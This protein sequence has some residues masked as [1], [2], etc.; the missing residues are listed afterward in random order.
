MK[1][2]WA[3]ASSFIFLMFTAVALAAPVPD[4]GQAK[5]YDVAG[6]VITCPSP[7]QALY[8]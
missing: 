5:C 7:G 1:K 8:G 4:T 2:T 6:N 3:I